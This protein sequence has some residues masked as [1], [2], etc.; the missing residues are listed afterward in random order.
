M[1]ASRLTAAAGFALAVLLVSAVASAP[2]M[3]QG[4]GL[5]GYGGTSPLM[6][7]ASQ[8]LPYS[9]S[10]SGFMPFRMRESAGSGLS[11]MP[12]RSSPGNP[13]RRPFQLFSSRGMSRKPLFSTSG[14]AMKS[15]SAGTAMSVMPP[16]FGYP[17]R[18]PSL[19]DP[20]SASIGMP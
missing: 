3:A 16:N 20:G 7:S 18:Q 8:S 2:A 1:L 10:F 5:S 17:F 14:S 9:G 15:P 6:G 12:R 19:V 4:S 13:L 11:F